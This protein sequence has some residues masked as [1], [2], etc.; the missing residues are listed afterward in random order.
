MLFERLVAEVPRPWGL[1]FILC[2][3]I[4]EKD[5]F[6]KKPFKNNPEFMEMMRLLVGKTEGEN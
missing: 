6:K 1:V 5:F 3:L 2:D 4:K